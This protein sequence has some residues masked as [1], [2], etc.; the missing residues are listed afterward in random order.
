MS[1]QHGYPVWEYTVALE[2]GEIHALGTV[3]VESHD[4]AIQD[5]CLQ[6]VGYGFMIEPYEVVNNLVSYAVTHPNRTMT[7]YVTIKQQAP[8][9]Q[10]KDARISFVE[11]SKAG[12][13]QEKQRGM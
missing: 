5:V 11:E 9:V 7:Y 2:T 10:A 12:D 8:S 6:Q 3:Q 1:S 4:E 13:Q